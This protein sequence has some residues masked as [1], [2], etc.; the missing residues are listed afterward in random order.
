M[1]EMRHRLGRVHDARGAREA[2]LDAAEKVFAEHGFDGTRVDVIAAASSY[3]KGLLFRYFGSKLDLYAAVIRRADEQTR[4][5]QEQ[6]IAPLLDRAA[7][8]DAD[9]LQDLFQTYLKAYFDYLLAH[10]PIARI[11][12]WEMAEG[13][14]TY[15]QIVSERDFDEVHHLKPLLRRL[16]SAGLVRPDLDPFFQLITAEMYSLAYLACLPL[17]Q[18]FSPGEDFTSAEAM[19]RAREY[20]AKFVSQGLVIDPANEGGG[21]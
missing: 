5:L 7:V 15:A 4:I 10:P 12:V 11:Y 17:A 2:I 14:K 20:N 21:Q 3:N 1:A 19:A 9:S 18:L 6:S 8:L 16:Q 13:W